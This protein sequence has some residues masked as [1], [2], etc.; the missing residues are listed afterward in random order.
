M[1]VDEQ[2]LL[3]LQVTHA[4]ECDDSCTA[5]ACARCYRR[6]GESTCSK[7]CIHATVED[8]PEEEIL[9]VRPDWEYENFPD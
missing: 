8:F 5:G 4:P 6:T 1:P 3:V 7:L 9:A 2:L